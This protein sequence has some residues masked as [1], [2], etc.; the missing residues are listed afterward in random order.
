MTYAPCCLT[1]L[2][3]LKGRRSGTGE[4]M[5][6]SAKLHRLLAVRL[7]DYYR[8][9]LVGAFPAVSKILIPSSSAALAYPS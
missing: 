6:L 7:L 3:I 8:T 4:S 5:S 9:Y 2:M 1:N